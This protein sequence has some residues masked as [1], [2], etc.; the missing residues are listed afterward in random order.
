MYISHSEPQQISENRVRDHMD[1]CPFPGGERESW[2]SYHTLESYYCGKKISSVAIA[3]VGTRPECRRGGN[4]RV[5]LQEIEKMAPERGWV[6]S[7]MHPFSFSYYRKFGYDKI[8]DHKIIRFPIEKLDFLPRCPDF[9]RVASPETAA[10]CVKVFTKFSEMRNVAFPR[11]GTANF[12]TEAV[13]DNKATYVRYDDR[14]EPYAYV[15][16][17]WFRHF[18]VNRAASDGLHVVEFGFTCPQALRDVLGFVRMFEGQD[19]EVI[20]DNCAMAPEMDAMLKHYMHT[21]YTIVPDIGC[22]IFDVPAILKA[23]YYPAEHGAFTV[24]VYDD[25][26]YTNG[27]YEVEYQNGSARVKKLDD[28]ADADVEAP[29]PAFTQLMYGYDEYDPFRATFLDGVRVNDPASDFFKV[30]HKKHNGIFDHF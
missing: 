30:F 17:E 23:N 1:I 19:R 15:S 27:V 12:P 22:R 26:P 5:M 8:A 9:V 13:K 4:V 2:M 14:G 3:G 7:L 20:I 29:M 10:D 6:V 28:S 11:Y 24:R 25:L 18:E 21:D 16:L